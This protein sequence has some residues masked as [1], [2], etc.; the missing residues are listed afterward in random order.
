MYERS[1]YDGLLDV[2]TEINSRH[3]NTKSSMVEGA[4]ARE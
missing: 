4:A 2:K 3:Y 1:L